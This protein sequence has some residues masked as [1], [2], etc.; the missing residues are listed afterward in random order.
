MRAYSFIS[1]C[2]SGDIIVA[3][4]P[5]HMVVVTSSNVFVDV[6][7]LC[8]MRFDTAS[9]II[10]LHTSVSVWLVEGSGLSYL[11][12]DSGWFADRSGIRT[13]PPS[14]VSRTVDSGKTY[15]VGGV[16]SSYSSPS[17]RIVVCVSGGEAG[18]NLKSS[19]SSSSSSSSSS[20]PISHSTCDAGG[21]S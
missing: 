9:S 7:H 21:D 13:A 16:V 5:S 12:K 2:H 8:V 6:R 11:V 18:L 15:N 4:I 14:A 19:L 10:I 1:S 17:S 3:V 20:L